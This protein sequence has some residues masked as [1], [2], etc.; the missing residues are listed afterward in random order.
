MQEIKFTVTGHTFRIKMDEEFYNFV[1]DDLS[2]LENIKENA[3]REIVARFLD[4]AH[5]TFVITKN[6]KQ[7]DDKVDELL[8]EIK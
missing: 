1:K 7:F 8:K 3:V 6:L 5:Q 4:K 2:A